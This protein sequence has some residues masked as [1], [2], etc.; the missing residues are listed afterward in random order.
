MTTHQNANTPTSDSSARNTPWEF[1]PPDCPVTENKPVHKYK[2]AEHVIP[3][4]TGRCLDLGAGGGRLHQTIESL[5]YAWI[6][7]DVQFSQSLTCLADGETLPFPDNTFDIVVMCQVMEHL[8]NPWQ[9]MRE[10]RRVLRPNGLVY[11]SSSF[12]EPFHDSY[13]H[14]SHWGLKALFDDTQFKVCDM[15]PGS[16]MFLPTA[17]CLFDQA[18]TK[19]APAS[20]Q[21]AG[22]LL[23]NATRILGRIY[24]WLR[25]GRH[26]RQD[27]QLDDFIRKMPLRFAGYIIWTCQK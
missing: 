15:Q 14:L 2:T 4:G 13:F 12:L 8:R 16:S 21:I 6:G 20:A 3:V 24:I 9:T 26:S 1:F 17:N 7:V 25:F 10:V 11:G 22:A 5:G 18:G 19:F 27:S 23:F